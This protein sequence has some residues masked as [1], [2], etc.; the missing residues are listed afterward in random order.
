MG[1][2]IVQFLLSPHEDWCCLTSGTSNQQLD[3][4]IVSHQKELA[5]N[6]ELVITSMLRDCA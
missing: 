3:L 1:H 6:P 2:M 4:H 5:H